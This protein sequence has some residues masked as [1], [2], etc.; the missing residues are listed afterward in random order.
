MKIAFD[1]RRIA[2]FGVGTYIRNLLYALARSGSEHEFFLIH[3]PADEKHFQGLPPGFRFVSYATT[4]SSR[5]DH[6][7]LPR[8]VRRLGVQLTHIPL[9]RV[10]LLLPKPYV[11]TIHDLSTVFYDDAIEPLHQ[12]RLFR[13]RRGL[14][15]AARIIAVSGSTRRQAHRSRA[16]FRRTGC[17]TES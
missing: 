15:R 2:D 7:A 11:V 13:L 6:V 5:W 8:L 4:D 14:A 16:R 9:H 17:S 10:P 1:C 3:S 12:A